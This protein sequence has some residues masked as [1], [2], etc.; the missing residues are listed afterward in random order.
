M[1]EVRLELCKTAGATQT[2]SR[3]VWPSELGSNSLPLVE[4]RRYFAIRKWYIQAKGNTAPTNG[5]FAS[6]TAPIN[7]KSRDTL[8]HRD[9]RADAKTSKTLQ[10]LRKPRARVC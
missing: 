6:F 2:V 5:P 10:T 8:H 1:F 7:L 9:E 3:S 4:K